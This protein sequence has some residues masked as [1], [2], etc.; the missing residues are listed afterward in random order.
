MRFVMMVPLRRCGSNAVR[1]RLDLHP[2]VFAP[3]PLHIHDFVPLLP[4]YGDLTIDENFLRLI[5]DVVGFL[6]TSPVRWSSFSPDPLQLYEFLCKD[7]TKK[8]SLP[9]IVYE[10]YRQGAL[11]RG[12][13]TRVIVDKSQDS[14]IEWREWIEAVPDILFLD[15]IRDPRAQIS[16]MNRCV[17]HDFHTRL[18]LD[19]WLQRR[20]IIEDI[21]S[22]HPEK[23]L[24]IR[25]EDF[26][27]Q[28]ESFFRTVCDFIGIPFFHS[29]ME[30]TA[31][32]EARRMSRASP[33]WENNDSIPLEFPL[34][35]YLCSLSC[36]E[37][38]MIEEAAA[39]P[40][41]IYNYKTMETEESR[42]NDNDNE[43]IHAISQNR[44]AEFLGW[45]RQHFPGDYW[46]RSCRQRYL[47]GLHH[48]NASITPMITSA[49]KNP[50]QNP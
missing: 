16:S 17:L 9:R 30:V 29:I 31:S 22:T 40:M 25:Y 23:I 41:H 21:R 12:G 3:Y 28:P 42:D 20:G 32:G 39:R 14:V 4:M 47:E 5:I 37:V 48:H 8:R 34:K 24:T 33:L 27:L 49:A 35:K 18:N 11:E 6:H 19:T 26:V 43:D 7:K 13:E 36:T 15:V 45:L 44:R 2:H 50:I 46:M 1:L 10:I 38:S